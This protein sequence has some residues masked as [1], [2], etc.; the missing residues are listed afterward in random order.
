MLKAPWCQRRFVEQAVQHIC[1]P[2]PRVCVMTWPGPPFQLSSLPLR[3]HARRQHGGA[4]RRGAFY[5]ET[6]DM[7]GF[8]GTWLS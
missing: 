1:K 2:G 6:R 7:I 3:C 8:F 5:A 4:R